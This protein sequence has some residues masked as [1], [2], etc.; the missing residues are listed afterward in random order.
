VH[1]GYCDTE[2]EARTYK[3][4]TKKP[5]CTNKKKMQKKVTRPYKEDIKGEKK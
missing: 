5:D 3:E 1:E 4:N 2:K